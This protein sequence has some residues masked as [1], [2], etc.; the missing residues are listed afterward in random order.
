MEMD[1]LKKLARLLAGS[2]NQRISFGI[3]RYLLGIK[4]LDNDLT[5]KQIIHMISDSS[6]PVPTKL[7]KLLFSYKKADLWQL[8]YFYKY[9]GKRTLPISKE[10]FEKELTK[11]YKEHLPDPPST[12]QEKLRNLIFLQIF[13]TL[14]PEYLLRTYKPIGDYNIPKKLIR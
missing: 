4:E 14:N 1:I 6:R 5:E 2:T 12:Y 11:I 7:Q 8:N 10:E 13:G 3:Y 9:T